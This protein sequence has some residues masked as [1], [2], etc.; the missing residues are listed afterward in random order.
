[1]RSHRS[2]PLTRSYEG[3]LFS[4]RRRRPSSGGACSRHAERTLTSAT[5][6]VQEPNDLEDIRSCYLYFLDKA[7]LDGAAEMSP[8]RSRRTRA[9][10]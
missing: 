5:V 1:V 3:Q 4:A 7:A 9:P 10:N 8:R 2:A 6:S